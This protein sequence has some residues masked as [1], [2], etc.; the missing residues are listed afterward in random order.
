MILSVSRRTDI[1]AFYSEWFF[2]RIK[3]G[4]VYVRNP[5]N[6]HNISRIQLN[7]KVVDC[8]V[9]WTKNA[10]PLLARIDEIRDYNYYFQYT[11]NPYNR[12]LEKNVPKKDNVIETFKELSNKIGLSRMIWRYDPILMT[13]DIDVYYHIRYFEEIA[14]RLSTYTKRC[15]IS[16]IDNYQKTERNLKQTSARELTDSEIFL[17]VKELV[18]IAKY[19]GM[20][21]QT[22]AERIDLANVGIEH[23]RCIDNVIIEELLGVKIETSKDINQRKECGCVQSIDIGEYNTCGHHCLYCYA[24]FNKEVVERKRE[25][26]D[27]KSPLLIG[28][29]ESGDKI[30]ERK[31]C[32]LKRGNL[33]F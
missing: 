31:V 27:S 20:E 13:D 19:Y 1:P 4:F 22:C 8:I 25:K 24:N 33:L 30:S 11:I 9:F 2:E 21:I 3:E 6:I 10:K 17:M 7:P 26:H 32:P 23:G 28:N 16:F 12:E 15:T 14:K 29:V 18:P 5:M